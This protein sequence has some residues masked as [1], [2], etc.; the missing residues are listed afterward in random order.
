MIGV[1]VN[2]LVIV[3]SLEIP[4]TFQIFLK[5]TLFQLKQFYTGKHIL[6]FMCFCLKMQQY[7]FFNIKKYDDIHE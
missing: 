3:L 2:F 5:Y 6:T 7:H 1:Y 4:V